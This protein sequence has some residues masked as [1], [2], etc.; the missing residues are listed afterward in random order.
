MIILCYVQTNF[1]SFL[2]FWWIYQFTVF[3]SAENGY[4]VVLHPD[5]KTNVMW[6]GLGSGS[7]ITP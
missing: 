4:F 5:N 7:R 2:R 3:K 6:D 1:D